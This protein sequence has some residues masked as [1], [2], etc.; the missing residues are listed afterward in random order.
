MEQYD[1]TDFPVIGNLETMRLPG[2]TYPAMN[3][4]LQALGRCIRSETDRA[5]V[6]LMDKRFEYPAYRR[7]FPQDI[8]LNKPRDLGAELRKFY[9][10]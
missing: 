10:R 2:Y 7:Y 3:R 8:T 5:A 9:A 6:I 1:S 4:V